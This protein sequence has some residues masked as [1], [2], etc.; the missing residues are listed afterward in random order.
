M[1]VQ[2]MH[3]LVAWL[4]VCRDADFDSGSLVFRDFLPLVFQ[5]DGAGLLFRVR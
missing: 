1:S 2:I 5:S 4:L 3:S